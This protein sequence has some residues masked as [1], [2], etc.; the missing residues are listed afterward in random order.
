MK[1]T[2]S[3]RFYLSIMI[4]LTILCVFQMVQHCFQQK[5]QEDRIVYL[6]LWILLSLSSAVGSIY[7]WMKVFHKKESL[8]FGEVYHLNTVAA[9]PIAVRKSKSVLRVGWKKLSH[10]QKAIVRAM[11]ICLLWG[12]TALFLTTLW[13]VWQAPQP[14]PQYKTVELIYLSIGLV[15]ITIMGAGLA[16]DRVWAGPVGYIFSFL[17]MLWFPVGLFTGSL[18]MILLNYVA[19]EPIRFRLKRDSYMM[20]ARQKKQSFASQRQ[21][22]NA[23]SFD[24]DKKDKV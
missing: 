1:F 11:A 24:L 10:R 21:V 15:L 18:L 17:Q 4:L 23:L 7:G 2:H 12:I 20:G 5:L 13:W 16:L 14:W 6:S 19:K 22:N 8:R 9:N 3:K